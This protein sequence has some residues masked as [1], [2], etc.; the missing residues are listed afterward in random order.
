MSL[1]LLLPS[2]TQTQNPAEDAMLQ[3]GR[4]KVKLNISMVEPKSTPAEHSSL[5]LSLSLSI[6]IYMYTKWLLVC[7]SGACELWSRH[8]YPAIIK[9]CKQQL[10]PRLLYKKETQNTKQ[11]HMSIKKKGGR[12]PHSKNTR[13]A[14]NHLT[15]KKSGAQPPDATQA[16]DTEHKA[17]PYAYQKR[18]W[19]KA[20]FKK[21]RTGTQ[22]LNFQE[23]Q[24][25]TTRCY[26]SDRHRTQSKTICL[27]KKKVAEGHLQQIQDRHPIT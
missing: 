9:I 27:L 1:S 13:Q 14:P 16:T 3:I 6:Y 17:K 26:T 21:C 2:V 8:G 24:S 11:N 23:E 22:S 7:S 25:R 18:K 10:M 4:I 20:T 19:P 5:S 12:R 15:V